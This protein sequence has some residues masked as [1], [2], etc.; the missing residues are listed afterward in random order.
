MSS[1]VMRCAGCFKKIENNLFLSC[2]ICKQAY[3]LHCANV[4][5]KSFCNAMSHEHR[6][7]WK[8]PLCVSKQPKTDN[9]DTPV[10]TV[11]QGVMTRRGAA[12]VSPV[13][14][15]NMS[16]VSD[17]PMRGDLDDITD[18]QM[19]ALE[20]RRFREELSASRIQMQLLNENMARLSTGLDNCNAR[21]DRLSI[22]V[23][24]LERQICEGSSSATSCE[25]T[26][27]KA[28][29]QLK[30]ELND[31]DQELLLNDIEISGVP[32][33]KGE[34]VTHVTL[35]LATKLGIKL[36]EEDVVSASRVG[37]VLRTSDGPTHQLRPRLIVVR[38]A[39]RTL[40][41]QFL[42]EA[43]I[44]RGATTG[45]AGLPGPSC[46]FYVNERLTRINRYVFHQAR[47]VAKRC[48]WRFVWTRNGK[49]FVR[50]NNENGTVRHRIGS[51]PDLVRV[52]G[53]DN[54]SSIKI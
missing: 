23:D 8:C 32:E 26:L 13:D 44:R 6:A 1:G 47:D 2:S 45:D 28:I 35:T 7:A 20:I 16:I 31:R 51:V 29:E 10:R 22:R 19:L 38:L 40:R 54:V 34:N 46:R 37:S 4:A 24:N 12:A 30:A 52:F 43:R 53:Q 33:Q 21:V 5:E 49:I 3:D 25:D 41:D 14:Q 18:T 39:R 9:T 11:T 17:A 27:M 48:G 15:L 36:S 50:H 42:H